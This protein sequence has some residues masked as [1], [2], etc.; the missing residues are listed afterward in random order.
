MEDSR[1]TPPS[2]GDRIPEQ[3]A[4]EVFELASRLYAEQKQS[5][6]TEDLVAAG[7]EVQIP[8]EY[9]QEA[10]RQ[11]QE[12]Q[13]QAQAQQAQAQARRRQLQLA[14]IGVGVLVAGWAALTYNAL[15]GADQ[16]VDAAWAQVENQL[17][18]RADLIPNLVNA[19]QA[20]A[21]QERE[22]AQILTD[23]R[24]TY[25]EAGTQSEQI[26]AA[27]AVN[28]AL[29]QFQSYALQDPQLRGNQLFIGLQD[30]LAGTENR[31]AVERMRYNQSVEAYNRRVR[32]FPN[33]VV[34]TLFGFEPQPFFEATNTAV[35]AVPPTSP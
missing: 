31:I 10:L 30:E 20:G 19:T 28:D 6:S 24:Q 29:S 8:P 15:S 32:S 11:V 9:I 26:A 22:L 35:P 2:S 4:P 21:Q 34:A 17:Q 14:A 13:R 1:L 7:S 23:A 5:Y 3:L 25:L 16:R 27:A 18:R 12:R 33:S